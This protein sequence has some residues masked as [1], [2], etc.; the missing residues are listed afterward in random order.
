[1][2]NDI[3]SSNGTLVF[4]SNEKNN[5]NNNLFINIAFEIYLYIT[6]ARAEAVITI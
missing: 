3:L 1:M 4:R 5:N 2:L 6:T